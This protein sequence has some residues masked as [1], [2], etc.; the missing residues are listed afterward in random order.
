MKTSDLFARLESAGARYPAHTFD[1]TLDITPMIE[2][3]SPNADLFFYYANEEGNE[4]KYL[5]IQQ[6]YTSRWCDDS[7]LL[8][9]FDK[10]S[11]D[12]KLEILCLYT[13]PIHEFRHHLDFVLTP[14]GAYFYLSLAQEFLSFQNLSPFLLQ[15][16]KIIPKGVIKSLDVH[17][18]TLGQ[19]IPSEWHDEWI[20]FKR[21]VLEFEACADFRGIEPE[22]SSVTRDVN[23]QTIRA[24]LLGFEF[25][26]VTINDLECSFSPKHRPSW[27]M[28]AATLLEGRAILESLLW[29]MDTLEG[30]PHLGRVL[31]N[32][33]S[34]LYPADGNYDYRFMLDLAAG[35]I[36][37]ESIEKCLE[38]EDLKILRKVF[39]VIDVAAW[40]ALHGALKVKDGQT[41]HED[42]FM[43]LIYALHE[44]EIAYYNGS[45]FDPFD[46]LLQIEQSEPARQIGLFPIEQG[47]KTTLEVLTETGRGIIN[48]I[49]QA[50]IREHFQYI[51]SQL[52]TALRHRQGSTYATPLGAP[53][54]GN[55]ILYIDKSLQFIGE[56]YT[57]GELVKE[58]FHFRNR[59]IFTPD[60]VLHVRKPL[61]ALFGLAELVVVCDC[62]TVIS[63]PVPKWKWRDH[64][65]V[66]C[67]N[68]KRVNRIEPGKIRPHYVRE[69]NDLEE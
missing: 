4:G 10:L 17:L 15:N 23:G 53:F 14:F 52:E 32:Y 5:T 37:C 26:M 47:L 67:P 43:R 2:G 13:V 12:E 64:H 41:Y 55:A 68:C 11:E 54:Y 45:Q 62:G 29:I 16:Q 42:C 33:I 25:E 49:W 8:D 19:T 6:L 48:E 69:R 22:L 61:R 40:F 66:V 35:W 38:S 60:T 30:Y 59:S 63:T 21:K 44:L 27:Y 3:L 24:H 20:I 9:H 46:L 39:Y 58:W 51:F 57:P 1:F 56:E 28:R 34:T 65:R 50:E 18:E 31:A 7:F 36:G